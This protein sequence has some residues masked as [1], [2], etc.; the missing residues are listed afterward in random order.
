MPTKIYPIPLSQKF[1]Q[2][3]PYRAKYILK[4]IF[5][6]KN[7]LQILS[8]YLFPSPKETTIL[9]LKNGLKF[10][11]RKT[12]WDTFVLNEIIIKKEYAII[13]NDFSNPKT[14]IDV[15]AHIGG[16]CVN[17]A[18]KFPSAKIFCIE[19]MPKN[20]ELL[21]QNIKQNGLQK[22]ITPINAAVVGKKTKANVELFIC[23]ENPACNSLDKGYSVKGSES[24]TVKAISFSE[25]FSKNK[26]R[27]CDILKLDCENMELEIIRENKREF[28]KIK[29]VILE[30]HYLKN[31]QKIKKLLEEYGYEFQLVPNTILAYAKRKE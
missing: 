8:I 19:P 25:I 11:V 29:A 24:I 15:G 16:F 4:T 3:I 13:E 22:R 18:D 20:F 7:P 17:Y 5:A 1:L 31:L 9:E 6:Y 23:K 12:I 14:I 21:S 2:K 27:Q 10:L 30:Y 28:Q 26:I